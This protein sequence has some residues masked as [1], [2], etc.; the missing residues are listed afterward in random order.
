MCIK[1]NLSSQRHFL[2]WLNISIVAKSNFTF[3]HKILERFIDAEDDIWFCFI[4]IFKSI[5]VLIFVRFPYRGHFEATSKPTLLAS[6]GQHRHLAFC[7]LIS[8]LPT[9]NKKKL[10]SSATLSF[11]VLTNHK[12]LDQS[13][14]DV[15]EQYSL[16]DVHG[17]SPPHTLVNLVDTCEG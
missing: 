8:L 5:A 1:Y 7:D 11:T 12:W 10:Q 14:C 3:E 9:C 2:D 16:L 15:V 6:K 13:E 4:L 17:S